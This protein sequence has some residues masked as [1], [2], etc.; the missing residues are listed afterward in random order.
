MSGELLIDTEIA[1]A[2]DP[3]HVW[4]ILT[5]LA[6]YGRWNPWIVSVAG[7][8]LPGSELRLQ[9]VHIPGNPATEG[10]V[11]LVSADFPEMRWEGGHP[12]RSILKGDHVFRCAPES[13]GCRFH[14]FEHFSG[15][16]AER[17]LAD[18]GSRIEANFRLFNAAL[19]RMAEG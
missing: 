13:G 5:D 16:S 8:L 14:H 6:G 7:A 9:S 2:A 18:F 10:A 4:R 15:I 11:T 17:L 12:D 19:K 1:I 3:A